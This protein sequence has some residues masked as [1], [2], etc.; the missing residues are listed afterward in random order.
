M[1]PV[2]RKVLPNFWSWSYPFCSNNSNVLR[3]SSRDHWSIDSSRACL[4]SICARHS[5]NWVRLGYFTF[6]VVH[7]LC[8]LCS[9]FLQPLQVQVQRV[10][11]IRESPENILSKTSYGSWPSW[12]RLRRLICAAMSSFRETIVWYKGSSEDT[13]C[14]PFS[15]TS[16]ASLSWSL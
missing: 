1:Q 10:R 13:A 4:P 2:K 9:M 7:M 11:S 6:T 8:Q 15:Y 16:S 5:R 14:R 3:S 12:Q